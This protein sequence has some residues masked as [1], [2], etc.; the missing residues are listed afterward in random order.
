MVDMSGEI[1]A[2]FIQAMKTV[3]NYK[4]LIQQ[5]QAYFLSFPIAD[6]DVY[7]GETEGGGI[8][9]GSVVQ[10][11]RQKMRQYLPPEMNSFVNSPQEHRLLNL[12]IQAAL[13]RRKGCIEKWLTE[14]MSAFLDDPEAKTLFH[15]HNLHFNSVSQQLKLCTHSCDCCFQKCFQT[16]NHEGAHSCLSDH[17]C[18]AQCEFCTSF[19]IK[20][21]V[22]KAGH[23]G[24]HTCG[25]PE[26][27]CGAQCDLA[28][29]T[30][31][32]GQTCQL[33]PGHEGGHMCASTTH[34]CKEMCQLQVCKE[35][36]TIPHDVQH[37][38]HQCAT[39]GCP[40]PCVLCNKKCSSSDHFHGASDDVVHLCEDE[41][42]CVDPN[43][44]MANQCSHLGWC[45]IRPELHRE[46]RTFHGKRGDFEYEHVTDQI[47]KRHMCVIKI[48]AGQLKH[49][50]P[51]SHS[52]DPNV[53]HYCGEPCASCHYRC[54]K[55]H[56]HPG[57]H[58]TQHGNMRNTIF[59]ADAEDI[60]IG[61][62]K[63]ARGESGEAE[64]CD[65]F[66]VKMG[67]GHA[68][69]IHCVKQKCQNA[70]FPEHRHA[71]AQY[72]TD[73]SN[74]LELDELTHEAYFDHIGFEDPCLPEQQALFKKCGVKCGSVSHAQEKDSDGNKV[75]RYCQLPVWHEP[76]QPADPLP[77][78]RTTGYISQKG[79]FFECVHG[80]FSTYLII[81]R[82]GSMSSRSA[83]P[84]SQ[85]IQAHRYFS[86][87]NNC[88]GAVYECAL[89][90][91]KL[92]AY[93]SP[94]DLVT[95]VPFHHS[96]SVVFSNWSV[97]YHQQ[98]LDSMMSITPGGGTAFVSGLASAYNELAKERR[99]G[100]NS[101]T[102]KPV[103]ILLTDS[104]AGDVQ[105]TIDYL[106]DI[107]AKE[108]SQPS[109]LCI[110][111]LG[112][113][114]YVNENF[115]QNIAKIGNG[116]YRKMN[117][118]NDVPMGLEMSDV[119]TALAEQPDINVGVL[120]IR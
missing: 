106:N 97:S 109:P 32:C 73:G 107:M 61:D 64:T 81:D 44:K 116:S 43:T 20:G 29:S 50:G 16:L 45:E 1:F 89:K 48:P 76:L 93:S 90:Y 30:W 5:D 24:K 110:Q 36:C 77:G 69:T 51:C 111:A 62:R 117:G 100:G 99:Q 101:L 31:N 98:I 86:G 47:K 38:R 42:T 72:Q 67:R 56:G 75:V 103:F 115:L 19:A 83:V 49:A 17:K 104:G 18:Y 46:K 14:N 23:V 60:D 96:S 78:G 40:I 8:D 88:L 80:R 41:H 113:G 91:V 53:L 7:V 65:S 57:K 26:H 2:E 68:H 6:A 70:F 92:R 10:K 63:Y 55:P 54:T 58:S 102:R 59:V 71:Q 37:D 4:H 66:C 84:V 52:L 3:P 94:D 21:C 15:V 74:P 25:S 87:V 33:L 39:I 13:E 28:R 105:Q 118:E 120:T 108:A 22:D 95:F 114:Q 9:R 85:E 112:V 82:S 79:H 12:F 34:Y 119:F 35:R 27:T 11:L